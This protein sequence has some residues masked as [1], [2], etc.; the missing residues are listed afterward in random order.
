MTQQ[1]LF[2][3][4][5]LAPKQQVIAAEKREQEKQLV[6][7]TGRIRSTIEAFVR[8]RQAMKGADAL[9]FTMVELHEYVA[10]HIT[11]GVAPGSTDR[12]LRLLRREGEVSYRVIDR[13][14]SIYELLLL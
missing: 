4:P 11:W 14:A 7:V 1:D 9:L 13:R 10:K 3:E 5:G 8:E 2:G 12:I 6:R